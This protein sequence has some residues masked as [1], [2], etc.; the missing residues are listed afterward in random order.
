MFKLLEPQDDCILWNRKLFANSGQFK[1]H[2]IVLFLFFY[3]NNAHK[4]VITLCKKK[5]GTE[6]IKINLESYNRTSP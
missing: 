4:D 5:E 1:L 3:L 2:K 6:S